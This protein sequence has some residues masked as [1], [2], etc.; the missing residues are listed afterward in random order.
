MPVGL[1]PTYLPSTSLHALSLQESSVSPCPAVAGASPDLPVTRAA[2]SGQCQGSRRCHQPGA[3]LSHPTRSQALAQGKTGTLPHPGAGSRL[4]WF[5][6]LGTASPERRAVPFPFHL[7]LRAVQEPL[8]SQTGPAPL[9]SPVTLPRVSL[10]PRRGA[11]QCSSGRGCLMG[12]LS[13]RLPEGLWED[14]FVPQLLQSCP[15]SCPGHCSVQESAAPGP[16]ESLGKG[17]WRQA[18]STGAEHRGVQDVPLHRDPLWSLGSGRASGCGGMQELA[19][20]CT[21]RGERWPED[22]VGGGCCCRAPFGSRYCGVVVM[23]NPHLSP[24]SPP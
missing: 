15:T 18:G 6:W 22:A 9:E 4:T 12:P 7:C 3:P 23:R 2:G 1:G 16:R 21:P 13:P 11:V 24:T 14:V 19:A 5:A 10:D 17:S 20:T 8:W